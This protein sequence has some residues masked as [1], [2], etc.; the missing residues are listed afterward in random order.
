MTECRSPLCRRRMVNSIDLNLSVLVTDQLTSLRS[1][2]PGLKAIVE[3]I[4]NREDFKTF[5]TQ[6]ALRWQNTGQR[7]PRREGPSEDSIVSS[8]SHSE[9]ARTNNFYIRHRHHQFIALQCHRGSTQMYR[10]IL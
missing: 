3:S 4:D 9:L 10:F 7:G 1:S 6:Y 5:M 2:G 8:V